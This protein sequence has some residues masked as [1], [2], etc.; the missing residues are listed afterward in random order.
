MTLVCVLKA[1]EEGV[2]QVSWRVVPMKL[3]WEPGPESAGPGARKDVGLYPNNTE[4]PWSLHKRKGHIN[5]T[6]IYLVDS[7]LCFH[8]PLKESFQIVIKILCAFLN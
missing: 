6:F 5:K 4:R 3:E 2:W 8:S 1:P 7:Y